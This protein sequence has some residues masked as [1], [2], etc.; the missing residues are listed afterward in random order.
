MKFERLIIG[1]QE[2]E[3]RLGF[4]PGKFT[5]PSQPLAF[6]IALLATA[7]FYGALH[8]IEG[9]GGM[10]R[11][12]DIFT[13]RGFIQYFTTFGFLWG[14]ALVWLKARKVDVQAT[15]LR[16]MLSRNFGCYR[17]TPQN[18]AGWHRWLDEQADKPQDYILLNRLRVASGSSLM[19]ELR[20]CRSP[21]ATSGAAAV[22]RRR[23][24]RL[25]VSWRVAASRRHH[26]SQPRAPHC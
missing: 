1:E 19:L 15:A 2:L 14:G 8:L 6:M 20:S 13:K 23:A 21:A 3:A 25:Q 17:F 9:N 26:R 12:V 16:L 22:Q 5:N 11:L 10:S 24:V 7:A 4:R 18:A